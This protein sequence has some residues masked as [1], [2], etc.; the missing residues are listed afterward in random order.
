MTFKIQVASVDLMGGTANVVAFDQPTSGPAKVL[1]VQFSFT[2]SGGEGHEKDKGN[3][4]GK[5]GS[6]AG[7]ER[8]L[9]WLS[10][11]KTRLS[12]KESRAPGPPPMHLGSTS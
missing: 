2:P 12:K 5:A 8:D 4:C 7:S 3:C 1:N 6:S 9:I 10:N 11:E